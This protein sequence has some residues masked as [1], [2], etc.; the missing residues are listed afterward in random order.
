MSQQGAR[1]RLRV[2]VIG[3]GHLG[4]HHARILA[5]LPD[6]TLVAAVD[7]VADRAAAAVAGTAAEA[8]TDCQS[9]W[10]RVDAVT[11]AVPTA[12]HLEVAQ[13]FL[14]RGVHVRV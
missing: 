3:V 2:A 4:R 1:D 6:V 7:V 10:G 13:A 12:A 5:G 11:V 14:E 9:L 8:L